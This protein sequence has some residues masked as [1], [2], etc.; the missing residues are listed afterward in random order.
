MA[1]RRIWRGSS[2]RVR[3]RSG[4]GSTASTPSDMPGSPEITDYFLPPRLVRGCS[5]VA[6]P[7]CSVTLAVQTEPA[8][9]SA[10]NHVRRRATPL[11]VGL[12]KRSGVLSG[13][14]GDGCTESGCAINLAPAW[15]PKPP[16]GSSFYW[17][18]ASGAYQIRHGE[19]V[20]SHQKGPPPLGPAS[21][22]R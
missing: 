19:R 13:R 9:S 17:R 8:A 18:L 6:R 5:S 16:R 14:F 21:E 2:E 11:S 1:R 20:L 10:A 15:P 22:R 7:N 3:G 12:H 4:T